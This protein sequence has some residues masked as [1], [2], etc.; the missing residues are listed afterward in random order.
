MKNPEEFIRKTREEKSF[1]GSTKDDFLNGLLVRAKGAEGADRKEV[2]KK[3]KNVHFSNDPK[4]MEAV[5]EGVEPALDDSGGG[6][7]VSKVAETEKDDNLTKNKELEDFDA[8]KV[9]DRLFEIQ[10]IL[11]D[12]EGLV[13]W[14]PEDRKKMIG[15]FEKNK[16]IKEEKELKDKIDMLAGLIPNVPVDRSEPPAPLRKRGRPKK[17]NLTDKEKEEIAQKW[18]S[19]DKKEA[20]I[21]EY[22]KKIDEKIKKKLNLTEEQIKILEDGGSVTVENE[23]NFSENEEETNDIN[24]ERIESGIRSKKGK[25]QENNKRVK[26]TATQKIET[27]KENVSQ[28]IEEIKGVINKEF[29]GEPKEPKTRKEQ[30]EVKEKELIELNSTEQ[31]LGGEISSR[32]DKYKELFESDNVWRNLINGWWFETDTKEQLENEISVLENEKKVIKEVISS[33]KS[34]I[35]DL[36]KDYIDSRLKDIK[37]N[38]KDRGDSGYVEQVSGGYEAKTEELSGVNREIASSAEGIFSSVNEKKDFLNKLKDKKSKI[39]EEIIIYEIENSDSKEILEKIEKKEDE[40]L[41]EIDGLKMNKGKI[42]SGDIEHS[43]YEKSIKRLEDR[44]KKLGELK[45]KIYKEAGII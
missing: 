11:K 12:Q 30:I 8:D 31:E 29:G 23:D 14:A 20:E 38:E 10:K 36:K 5:F 3:Q 34:E 2:E 43:E 44:M 42:K 37:N 40:T 16:L 7:G 4:D 1:K 18:D 27:G 17:P 28:K 33:L 26:E 9:A 25:K 19:Q 45:G 32:K 13:A 39:E 41:N 6:D 15:F 21:L 35:K 22:R 24:N